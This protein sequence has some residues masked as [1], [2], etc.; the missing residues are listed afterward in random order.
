MRKTES[1]TLKVYYRSACFQQR[2]FS[3]CVSPDFQPQLLGLVSFLLPEVMLVDYF[4]CHG[5]L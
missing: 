2:F 5:L 4:S 3:L 1:V